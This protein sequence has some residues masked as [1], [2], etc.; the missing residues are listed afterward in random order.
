MY[1]RHVNIPKNYNGVRFQQRQENDNIPVKEHRPSYSRGVK[2][3]HSSLY[4]QK[5]AAPVDEIE[6]IADEFTEK[7]PV[8]KID[9][10]QNRE[11]AE[12][13]KIMSIPTVIL[14]KTPGLALPARTAANS[15]FKTPMVFSI[16]VSIS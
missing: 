3:S 15:F 12:K 2:S 6:Q 14:F 9:I 8:V 7:M 11:L 13:Y 16:L 4:N 1:T 10:D 5:I